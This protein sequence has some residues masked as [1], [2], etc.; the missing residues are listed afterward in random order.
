MSTRILIPTLGKKCLYNCI[1]SIHKYTKK[2]YTIT[3]LSDGNTWAEAINIGLKEEKS[4]VILMDDDIEVRKGWLNNLNEYK[5]LA[6]IIGWTLQ[7]PDGTLQCSGCYFYRT[8]E[9]FIFMDNYHDRT[10]SVRLTPN[11]STSC[12]F[13]KKKVFDKIGIFDNTTYK[14][15]CHYEDSDFCMRA[16]KAG[17]KI[18]VIP[19]TVIHLETETK[20]DFKNFKKRVI[21]NKHIFYNKLNNDK[22]YIKILEKN[23]FIER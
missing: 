9:K 19:E 1:D 17:F 14:N 15:G 5:K 8:K 6:D 4:D 18:M 13:I 7:R 22:K 21:I 11:I 2:P 16:V 10:R 23:N 12:A 20:K 3:L